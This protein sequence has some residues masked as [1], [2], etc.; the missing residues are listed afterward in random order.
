MWGLGVRS[1]R[2]DL[3]PMPRG[4][5][6][7][8][9]VP[10]SVLPAMGVLS[11]LWSEHPYIIITTA[12]PASK[13]KN[14]RITLKSLL[15]ETKHSY[16]TLRGHGCRFLRILRQLLRV[17]RISESRWPCLCMASHEQ[18]RNR[19]LKCHSLKPSILQVTY[20]TFGDGCRFWGY[21]SFWILPT[22]PSKDV[23]GK[24]HPLHPSKC[25]LIEE[26]Y[27]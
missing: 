15:Y 12:F 8:G 11:L 10:S 13:G 4:H 21:Q 24:K 9:H 19:P 20:F 23:A 22:V 26:N 3:V 16:F 17:I 18:P 27:T 2:S 25:Y 7:S 1:I 14:Q 6:Q 5:P